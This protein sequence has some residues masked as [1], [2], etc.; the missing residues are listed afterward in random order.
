MDVRV[1]FL[2]FPV[3]KD[4]LR[5]KRWKPEDGIEIKVFNAYTLSTY[6]RTLSTYQLTLSTYQRTLSSQYQKPKT[7][8]AETER[9]YVYQLA[10]LAIKS[11]CVGEVGGGGGGWWWNS[12]F[13]EAAGIVKT[14]SPKRTFGLKSWHIAR[15]R[16]L[17]EGYLSHFALSKISLA[18]TERDFAL[19]SSL[20]AWNGSQR[21][22]FTDFC[23]VSSR[24]QVV[25]FQAVPVVSACAKEHR[26]CPHKLS[27]CRGRKS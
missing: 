25:L 20:H 17:C 27:Q 19:H 12:G 7:I 10:C 13:P 1:L 22:S 11:S 21:D 15:T 8:V 26:L 16:S 23:S 5:D 14:I 24:I 9:T 2:T 6:Q 3:R 4:K 18:S